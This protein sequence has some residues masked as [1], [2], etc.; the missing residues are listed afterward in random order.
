MS[1]GPAPFVK[2]FIMSLS[3]ALG[4]INRRI[5][6]HH[7]R[8]THICLNLARDLDLSTEDTTTLFYAGLLHDIGAFSAKD[9]LE[10]MEFDCPNCYQHCESGFQILQKSELMRPIADSIRFH[11]DKYFGPNPSGLSQDEI[12]LL[13]QIIHISDRFEVLIK[14]DKDILPQSSQIINKIAQGQ[15]TWF[16]SKLVESLQEITA[17]KIF[18]IGLMPEFVDDILN[19][20]SPQDDRKMTVD[21][22]VD[23]AY[24][25]AQVVD[26]KSHFT[27]LHSVQVA[28]TAIKIGKSMGWS[29]TELK[30]LLIAGLL[31]DL[32]KLAIPDEILEKPAA[33]TP[34]EYDIIK[35]HPYFTYLTLSS[36]P[37]FDEVAQWAIYHHERL[38]G[39]GYPLEVDADN[40][41]Q[42]ARII[43]VADRFTA[44]TE[45]RPYRRKI[46]IPEAL[47]ILNG[48]VKNKIID[49]KIM[50]ILK[51]IVLRNG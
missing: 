31:H 32:G 48:D 1:D 16:N 26:Y 51:A 13:S 34:N 23:M 35:M 41:P 50:D 30:Y 28:E 46:P 17:S 29:K 24:I 14:D 6:K 2:T 37:G 3:H 8:V 20:F 12:P 38:D 47:R 7:Q 9:K 21:N 15:G 5:G 36:I 39:K 43:A 11:H 44:L 10:I 22:M 25:F 19:E 18:W 4:L 40:I 45:D 42:G 49:E 27:R 33:L